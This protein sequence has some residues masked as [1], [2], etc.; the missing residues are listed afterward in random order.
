MNKFSENLGKPDIKIAGLEIWIHGNQ[1]PDA[2]DY[3]DGNWMA[4]TAKCASR[5][6]CV[7]VSGNILHLPDLKHLMVT[8]EKLY[9]NLKGEAVLPCI[10]PELSM[11]LEASSLGQ[12]NM[13]VDI[14]PDHL[15]QEH[16]F[17]FEIDQ[18]YLPGLIS[19]CKKVL[20]RYKIKGKA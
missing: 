12:I 14:T 2:G 1:F 17:V 10:E 20:D 6:S 11:K 16:K 15:N 19:N 8:S 18:S 13:T 7:W 5:N 4:I 9:E 3:W